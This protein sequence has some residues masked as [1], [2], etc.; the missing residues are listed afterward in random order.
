MADFT[1]SFWSWFIIVPTVAGLIGMVALIQWLSGGRA[2]PG[3]HVETMGHVWDE[4][5]EE[6]NNPLPR[7]WLNLFYITLIFA[8]V[9]LVLYPGLGSF[10]GILNW[11]EVKQYNEEVAEA[12]ARYGPLYDQ[13][14]QESIKALGHNPEALKMGERLFAS[15]CTG[16]HGSDARGVTGFPNLRDN[17]WLYG[18]SPEAIQT[19]ILNGRN[20]FMPAWKTILGGDEAVHNVA[21]YVL[22]LSERKVDEEAAAAGQ[23]LYE[24]YCTAC[25]GADGK[26]NQDSPYYQAPNLTD[27]VWLYGG[28]PKAVEMSIAE[29]RQGKMPAF[30]DFLGE[31]KVHLLSA[32]IYNLPQ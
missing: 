7:W 27:N 28:S 13:Y 22:S 15:Y 26:G 25:H 3:E 2:K 19:T 30:R 4:N 17:D 1:S 20:A 14:R 9:Y 6:L 11:S 10:A 29:G 31:A 21:Q 23:P 32:Y 18:G 5:L 8:A 24:T 16:C 12:D